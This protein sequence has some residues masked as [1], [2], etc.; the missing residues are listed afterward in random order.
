VDGLHPTGPG[1]RLTRGNQGHGQPPSPNTTPK[2][3]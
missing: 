3:L 1:E 2:R